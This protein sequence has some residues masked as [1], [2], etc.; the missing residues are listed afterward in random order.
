[1][2][3]ELER[4]KQTKEKKPDANAWKDWVDELGVESSRDIYSTTGNST[5][6]SVPTTDK[7]SIEA[8]TSSSSN[9]NKTNNNNNFNHPSSSKSSNEN[10]TSNLLND[11]IDCNLDPKCLICDENMADIRFYPCGHQ[12]CCSDCSDC[13]VRMK[14]C[15]SCK[16]VIKKLMYLDSS[17]GVVYGVFDH[18]TSSNGASTSSSSSSNF[19]FGPSSSSSSSTTSLLNNNLAK[20]IKSD[21]DSNIDQLI[22]KNQYL[23]SKMMKIEEVANCGICL[24]NI[25]N[26]IFLC[27]H[28]ACSECAS[29]LQ[30]CH[31]CRKTITKKINVY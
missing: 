25:K 1:M 24:E 23:E 28:G 8:N 11:T 30:I 21:V 10:S 29:T 26:V 5:S 3:S 17:E 4:T 12:V 7:K 16:Q 20:C 9:I 22:S 13:I 27:G 19:P 2:F 14:K 18:N 15:I 6:S 31:M